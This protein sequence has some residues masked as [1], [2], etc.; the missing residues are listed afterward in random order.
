VQILELHAG[1]VEEQL[2]NQARVVSMHTALP[3][4]VLGNTL[5]RLRV[6]STESLPP[7]RAVLLA[8]NTEV[9]VAPKV[10]PKAAPAVSLASETTSH[11]RV[12]PSEWLKNAAETDACVA[13]VD[14]RAAEKLQIPPHGALFVMQTSPAQRKAAV[15]ATSPPRCACVV[16]KPH[17]DAYARHVHVAWCVRA[18]SRTVSGSTVTLTRLVGTPPPAR[19]ITL[20]PVMF[21]EGGGEG[22]VAHVAAKGDGVQESFVRWL[23]TFAPVS[24]RARAICE[25][26]LVC[27]RHAVDVQCGQTSRGNDGGCPGPHVRVSFRSEGD[28]ADMRQALEVFAL[29]L[30][31]VAN[32]DVSVV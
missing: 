32:K 5:I 26:S 17:T 19:N 12:L 28:N 29:D 22:G 23:R 6:T 1:H 8:P 16:I 25:G 24:K 9:V 10:R 31:S 7:S 11:M 14:A 3:V 21:G 30:A 20:A 2:L 13:Y 27:L 18:Q 15:D 4:W